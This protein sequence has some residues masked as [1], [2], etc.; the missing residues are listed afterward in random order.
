ML[1]VKR[2]ITEGGKREK[3]KGNEPE[4]TAR[5]GEVSVISVATATTCFPVRKGGALE[6]GHAAQVRPAKSNLK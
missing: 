6:E 4:A 3:E 1:S 2:G 5:D